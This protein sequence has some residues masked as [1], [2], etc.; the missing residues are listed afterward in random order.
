[1][2]IDIWEGSEYHIGTI[3]SLPQDGNNAVW[4]PVYE[5]V[6]KAARSRVCLPQIFGSVNEKTADGSRLRY[7]GS[8]MYLDFLQTQK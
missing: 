3:R 2:G 8:T 6:S 5:L 1:M 7:T 4:T